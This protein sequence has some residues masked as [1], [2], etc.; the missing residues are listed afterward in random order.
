MAI[1]GF[2]VLVGSAGS[3][4]HSG[5]KRAEPS[6]APFVE[7][8]FQYGDEF[9]LE[10]FRLGVELDFDPTPFT[11]LAAATGTER[12]D[13]DD[14]DNSGTWW[15][16]RGQYR[17]NAAQYIDLE[18]GKRSVRETGSPREFD[19]T[20]GDARRFEPWSFKTG[21]QRRLVADSYLSLVGDSTTNLGAA[22]RDELYAVLS[23]SAPQREISFRAAIGRVDSRSESGNAYVAG[24]A[25]LKYPSRWFPAYQTRMGLEADFLS[26]DRD[27]SGFSASADES[28][29]GGYFSPQL[30][31][32]LHGFV[33]L[34]LPSSD[35]VEIL[36]RIGGRHRGI[37]QLYS[38]TESKQSSG[39]TC[40]TRCDWRCLSA[41]PAFSP[42]D[43]CLLTRNASRW[44]TTPE[45]AALP[46]S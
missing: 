10:G 24:N 37:A 34:S 3:L 20:W 22:T 38:P 12:F 40:R 2:L 30:Y 8:L 42:V 4:L 27:H 19:L 7:L 29:S 9:D 17:P 21:Y 33:D 46:C 13:S 41:N 18:F 35:A 36:A 28:R 31:V 6:L 32:G 23:D 43:Y 25:A 1:L 11:S 44:P 39:S 26:Y 5:R 45:H 14:D 15:R 16:V